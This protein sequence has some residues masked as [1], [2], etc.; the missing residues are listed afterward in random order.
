MINGLRKK[1][2]WGSVEFM[3]ARGEGK[4]RQEGVFFYLWGLFVL[5]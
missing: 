2:L 4:K 1:K 3:R 5:D